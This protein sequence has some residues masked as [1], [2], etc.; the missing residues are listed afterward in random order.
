MYNLSKLAI[1][2]AMALA[3][4]L[5]ATSDANAD[6]TTSGT[7]YV[8][9]DPGA[10]GVF[11]NTWSFSDIPSGA[12]DDPFAGPHTEGWNFDD[13]FNFNVPDSE[14]ITF[15]AQANLNPDAG[16]EFFAA[17]LYILADGTV[18]GTVF[19]PV[20]TVEHSIAGGSFTLTSGTYQLE[21]YG[22][23]DKSG[24]TYSGFID[25]IPAVPEPSSWALM[26]F[27]LGAMG[28]LARRRNQA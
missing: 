16:T 23:F 18:L 27:G 1:A 22:M 21:L 13:F 19:T 17:G 26:L 9:M 10:P 6:T 14:V 24:G 11:K 20:N 15:S 3:L 12:T 5:V 8:P 25:G 2:S 28:E 7:T 4:S